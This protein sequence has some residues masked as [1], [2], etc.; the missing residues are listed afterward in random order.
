MLQNLKNACSWVVS[1]VEAG[2]DWVR[3]NWPAITA[4]AEDMV[5]RA[6][7]MAMT[8]VRQV[9]VAF[10]R[11]VVIG[12]ELVEK[13]EAMPFDQ[14]L[15]EAKFVVKAMSDEQVCAFIAYWFCQDAAQA[16]AV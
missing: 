15:A 10:G 3:D 7:E 5:R 8:Q 12:I 11:G 4:K 1:R 9:V 16:I 2:I 13:R 14:A 6:Y